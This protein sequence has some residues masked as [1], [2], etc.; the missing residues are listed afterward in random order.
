ME[1]VVVGVNTAMVAFAQGIGFAIPAPTIGWV[2]AV[3]LG[4]GKIER[5]RLGMAARSEVLRAEQAARQGR[6]RALHVLA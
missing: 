1:G 3:L 5:P 6:A 4:R 2:V